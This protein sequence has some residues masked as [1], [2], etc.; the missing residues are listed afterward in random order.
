LIKI[1][2]LGQIKS[3]TFNNKVIL[4]INSRWLDYFNS[5][6]PT[7]KA[8]IE[9]GKYVLIGPKVSNQDPTTNNN[10]TNQSEVDSV[11]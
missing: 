6:N 4:A 1:Q 10:R 11:E 5:E 2:E 9:N 7:F 3:H 8:V